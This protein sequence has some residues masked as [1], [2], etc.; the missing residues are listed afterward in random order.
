MT[1]KRE[2]KNARTKAPK[3]KLGGSR[4]CGPLL[5]LAGAVAV[6]DGEESGVGADAE[7]VVADRVLVNAV[8]RRELDLRQ[9]ALVRVLRRLKEE[10]TGGGGSV[11]WRKKE[12][13][14]WYEDEGKR[15]KKIERIDVVTPPNFYSSTPVP[16]PEHP[17]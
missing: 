14:K 6:V 10:T 9:S 8:H 4:G 3:K 2:K 11:C 13:G 12:N 1:R 17:F 15:N 16:P 5:Y 7:P